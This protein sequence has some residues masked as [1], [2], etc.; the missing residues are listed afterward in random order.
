MV[1]AGE[2]ITP[3]I[4][5]TVLPPGAAATASP[6][7]AGVREAGDSL[8]PPALTLLPLPAYSAT[9][10]T[11]LAAFR[12]GLGDVGQRQRG[13]HNAARKDFHQHTAV[14][15][16]SGGQAYQIIEIDV[17][18]SHSPS[19]WPR[20]GWPWLNPGAISIAC[21]EYGGQ[22]LPGHLTDDWFSGAHNFMQ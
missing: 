13:P 15:F 2:I 17:I 20:R 5:G 21:L 7:A 8:A 9:S 16:Y 18:H 12:H 22:R 1:N 3:A 10:I 19:R 4:A 14:C 6:V 11:H